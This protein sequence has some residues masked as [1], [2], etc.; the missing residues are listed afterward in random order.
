MTGGLAGRIHYVKG[1]PFQAGYSLGQLLGERLE[2]N[3]QAYIQ[4]I[5]KRGK[6]DELKLKAEAMTWLRRLPDRIKEEYEGMAEGSGLPLERLAE[7]CY[8]DQCVHGECSGFIA[9]IQGKT[10]VARNNDYYAP[11]LWGYG[12]IRE[13]DGCIPTLTFGLEG[14]ILTSTGINRQKLWLHYNYLPATDSPAS[15]KPS[16]DPQVFLTEALETCA[17]I[18][19]I[20]TLLQEKNRKEGMLLFVVD[21]KNNDFAMYECTCNHFYRRDPTGN[22]MAGTNHYCLCGNRGNFSESAARLNRLWS[23]ITILAQQTDPINLPTD[24]IHVLK[25]D[26][27]E[28]RG[29]FNGTVFANVACPDSGEIWHTFGGYPAAS[30]G[31]WQEIHWP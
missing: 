11:G 31:N 15:N 7:W 29:E 4:S 17:D 5:S 16:L 30:Q 24:L 22:W 6:L 28:G 25:D 23:L 9:R 3:I 13:I 27:I 18:E 10:W 19:S 1:T 14:D 2:A 8:A 20:E 26:G 12:L 21:G